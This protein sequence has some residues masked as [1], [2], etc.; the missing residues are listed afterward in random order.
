[1]MERLRFLIARDR[2]PGSPPR[3]Q[4]MIMFAVFLTAMLGMLG[5]AMDG[6]VYLQAK[7][8][9][10]AAADAGAMAGAR[11]MVKWTSTNQTKALPEVK[12]FVEGNEVGA[13]VPELTWCKYIGDNWSEVGDCSA[14]VPSN[15]SG[16][17][18]RT[19]L[20]VPMFF[21]RVVGEVFRDPNKVLWA[22]GYAK[23]RVMIPTPCRRTARSSSAAR[24]LGDQERGR[25]QHR[26]TDVNILTG[27]NQISSTYVN[28]TFRIHDKKIS[29]S[30][31]ARQT[32]R[33]QH[34]RLRLERGRW[35]L[36]SGQLRQDRARVVQVRT[37]QQDRTGQQ[38]PSPAPRAASRAPTSRT[39]A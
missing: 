7:R 36:R 22:K 3:G 28:Y 12:A 2:E 17:R 14:T 13:L 8:G 11:Q 4:V 18:V 27:S 31:R 35:R 19:R 37:R 23:A 5:L 15:A 10:Q 21:M 38:P 32:R 34:A 20:E 30:W 1:M 16:V 39:T 6:G 25:R 29:Q 26:N 9:A 24:C 33:L